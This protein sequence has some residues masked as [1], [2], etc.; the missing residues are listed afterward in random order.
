MAGAKDHTSELQSEMF[1]IPVPLVFCNCRPK[2][3]DGQTRKKMV[4]QVLRGQKKKETIRA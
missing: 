4:V 3:V 1:A 2:I